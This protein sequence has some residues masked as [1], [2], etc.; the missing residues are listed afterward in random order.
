MTELSSFADRTLRN[1]ALVPDEELFEDIEDADDADGA[2]GDT[3]EDECSKWGRTCAL[4]EGR[5]L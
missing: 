1:V 4:E 3:T 2:A 5:I